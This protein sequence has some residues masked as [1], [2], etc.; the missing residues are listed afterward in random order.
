M[1]FEMI[2]FIFHHRFIWIC[3]IIIPSKHKTLNERRWNHMVNVLNTEHATMCLLKL[4]PNKWTFQLWLVSYIQSGKIEMHAIHCIMQL[5]QSHTATFPFQNL[6]PNIVQLDKIKTMFHVHSLPL[7]LYW[8][9][10]NK[11]C[12]QSCFSHIQ[13]TCIFT[14]KRMKSVC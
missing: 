10:A 11:Y 13:F 6:K 3:D 1:Q 7:R 4:W 12:L 2:I 9:I 8:D 5:V 14:Y